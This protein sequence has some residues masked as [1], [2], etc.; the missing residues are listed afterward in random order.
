MSACGSGIAWVARAGSTP[1]LMTTDVAR[2]RQETD[3]RTHHCT[4]GRSDKGAGPTMERLTSLRGYVESF[5]C[6]VSPGGA[7]I[8][9]LLSDYLACFDQHTNRDDARALRHHWLFSTTRHAHTPNSL[10]LDAPPCTQVNSQGGNAATL[11]TSKVCDMAGTSTAGKMTSFYS[12]TNCNANSGYLVCTA[13][14]FR[15]LQRRPHPPK[16]VQAL[17]PPNASLELLCSRFRL[18]LF[19]LIPFLTSLR[20]PSGKPRT[21]SLSSLFSRQTTGMRR[22]WPRRQLWPRVQ[23]QERRHVRHGVD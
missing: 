21:R 13:A 22:A 18:T 12:T 11:H 23:Y 5:S 10:I 4:G 15:V 6:S 16:R 9:L 17:S 14:L 20:L 1:L 19:R 2:M 3:I 8:L 7:C